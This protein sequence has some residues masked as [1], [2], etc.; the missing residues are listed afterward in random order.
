LKG[1]CQGVEEA[2]SYIISCSDPWGVRMGCYRFS[3][4]FLV[5][6]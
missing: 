1:M 4:G 5:S 3:E 6:R 2:G